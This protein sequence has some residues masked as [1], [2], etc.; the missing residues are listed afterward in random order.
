MDP[1][2]EVRE[3]QREYLDFLDDGVSNAATTTSLDSYSIFFYNFQDDTGIY[4][5]K[6]REMVR[7]QNRRLVVNM[8]D[9][10]RK[11]PQRAVK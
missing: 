6:V 7:S 4:Y 1:E 10:R 11:N 5:D 8:N 2:Q 9:L 3:F